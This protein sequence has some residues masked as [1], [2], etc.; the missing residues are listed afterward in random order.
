MF[1][2][3]RSFLRSAQGR[4]PGISARSLWPSRRSWAG[5]AGGMAL[6]TLATSP[7]SGQAPI[8]ITDDRACS[9]CRI[10]L[11]SLVSL[12]S[13]DTVSFSWRSQWIAATSDHF[14]VAPTYNPGQIAIFDRRGSLTGTVGRLGPGP[15]EVR[16]GVIKITTGPGDSLHVMEFTRWMVFA[17]PEYEFVR[18]I[19]IRGGHDPQ[20]FVVI[21]SGG[22]QGDLLAGFASQREGRLFTIHLISAVTGEIIR[23]FDMPTTDES[24]GPNSTLRAISW[25]ESKLWFSPVERVKIRSQA[26]NGGDIREWIRTDGWFPGDAVG[27]TY[28]PYLQP[29]VPK[30]WDVHAAGDA[31]WVRALVADP[32]WAPLATSPSDPNLARAIRTVDMNKLYDTVIEVFDR[33][34]G[35]V[36]ARHRDDRALRFVAGSSESPPLVARFTMQPSGE[37]RIDILRVTLSRE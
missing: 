28:E 9:T 21:D 11:D 29:P 3:E 8:R 23:S 6:V 31:I 20:T 10:V 5:Y 7:G 15:G 33:E 26:L 27:T 37:V 30:V 16:R 25:R 32:D 19:T 4:L 14:I 12:E 18:E 1:G 35:R 24:R 22:N 17:P 2:D 34:T 36:L 13:R